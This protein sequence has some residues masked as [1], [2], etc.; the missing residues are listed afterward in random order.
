MLNE[1]INIK[2]NKPDKLLILNVERQDLELFIRSILIWWTNEIIKGI[3]NNKIY[4]LIS[5]IRNIIKII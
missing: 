2:I 5:I 1:K 4:L 3:D